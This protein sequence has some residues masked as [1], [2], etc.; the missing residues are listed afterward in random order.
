MKSS[1]HWSVS[2]SIMKF[3]I[4]KAWAAWGQLGF[5]IWKKIKW[6][7]HVRWHVKDQRFVDLFGGNMVVTNTLWRTS[8]KTE[9]NI[10]RFLWVDWKWLKALRRRNEAGGFCANIIHPNESHVPTQPE[11]LSGFHHTPFFRVKNLLYS[12]AVFCIKWAK[13]GHLFSQ[14]AAGKDL[15][16]DTHNNHFWESGWNHIWIP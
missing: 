4:I 1:R 16:L 13:W 14:P 15:G 6:F 11:I 9:R 3:H 7:T 2:L 10:Q 8:T 12:Q 5:Y